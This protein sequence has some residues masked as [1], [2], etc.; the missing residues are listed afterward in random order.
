[1]WQDKAGADADGGTSAATTLGE[2]SANALRPGALSAVPA[3]APS[4]GAAG[5]NGPAAPAGAKR[6]G[7]S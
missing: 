2:S 3:L 7:R 5:G 1:M 4:G 6:A